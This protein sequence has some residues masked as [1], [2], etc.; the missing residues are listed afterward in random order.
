MVEKLIPYDPAEDL[1]TDD[2]IEVFL[3]DAFETGDAA[4]I[5]RALGV[6]ARAKGMTKIARKTGLAREQLYRSLSENGNPTLET[7]MAVMKAI[8]FQITGKRAA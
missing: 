4:Y 1:T 5:A 7:T 8:G 3:T 2:A 6:V